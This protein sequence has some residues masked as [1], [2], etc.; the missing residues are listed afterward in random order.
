MKVTQA[1]FK[2]AKEKIM[3]KK[4]ESQKWKCKRA[5]GRAGHA[6]LAGSLEFEFACLRETAGRWGGRMCLREIIGVWVGSSSDTCKKTGTLP[7]GLHKVELLE[8][9]VDG[10][11][12][13][14]QRQLDPD[15]DKGQ[16]N[17]SLVGGRRACDSVVKAGMDWSS[18]L[19]MQK[20]RLM[21]L[22]A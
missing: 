20:M 7:R 13:L 3:F 1:D 19:S 22:F 16:M 5:E 11:R 12:A 2:K 14:R 6:I 15:D 8:A 10:G 4:A 21:F 9:G 17:K 18:F